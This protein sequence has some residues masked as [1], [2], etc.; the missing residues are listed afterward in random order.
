M[1][2]RPA[3]LDKEPVQ[4]GRRIRMTDQGQRQYEQAGERNTTSRAPSAGSCADRDTDEIKAAS[5]TPAQGSIRSTRR[6][7]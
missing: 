3:R 5:G 6:P 1:S 4:C 2:T 7:G